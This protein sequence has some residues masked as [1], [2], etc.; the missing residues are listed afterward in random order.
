MLLALSIAFIGFVSLLY[1]LYY[2]RVLKTKKKSAYIEFLNN[3]VES[4]TNRAELPNVSVL[5]PTYNEE[6]TINTK[7][8]NLSQSDYPLEKIEVFVLDD[9]STDKTR[10]LAQNAFKTFGLNGK[11]L[12]HEK[13]CGV[14]ALYNDGFAKANYDFILTTD[15][16][17]LL[18]PETLLKSV[19]I[20]L[21]LTDV[22]GV[23]AKMTP[24][25]AEITA[26]TRTADSYTD[27][28]NLMLEAESSIFST[29]PGGSS[30]MLVR[31]S[32]FSEIPAAYGS[33]DGNISLAIIKNGFKFI[34]APCVNFLEPMSQRF[35]E[36]RRQKVR[37][38][39]RLIQASLLNR[40]I[41][42][43]SKYGAFGKSIF[44]LRLLMMTIAPPLILSAIFLFLAFAFTLSLPAA[45]VLV[46][47]SMIFLLLGTQTSLK[48]PNLI[49]SFLIH[50]TYLLAGFF[51][52]FKKMGAWPHLERVQ[53]GKLN[54]NESC[55]DG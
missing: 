48:V 20:M 29:F 18:L 21:K 26:S 45:V 25:H 37:R 3:I 15:A 4:P 7:I 23:A 31:K 28:Y 32:A 22:G 44:P 6:A 47:T 40:D 1:V 42:F 10:E 41:C 52:S 13:R 33:S 39:T 17:A 35:G 19:K 9:C 55:I 54:F 34:L 8:E 14:N 38:A 46:S 49:T 12:S 11:V 30:C 16:D 51:L 50:Q 43:S 27:V 53:N 5:I 36:L 24:I 2:L